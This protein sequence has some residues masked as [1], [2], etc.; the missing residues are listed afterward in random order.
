MDFLYCTPSVFVIDDDYEILINLKENGICYIEI[1]NDTFYEDGSGVLSSESTLI[2]IRIPPKKLDRA[3]KYRVVYRRPIERKAYFSTLEE[4]VC[5]EFDFKPIEKTDNINIYLI[6]DVHYR[7]NIAKTTASYFGDDI[8]LFVVNGD[9]G[10]VETVENYLEVCRFVGE[11]SLGKIPVI[12]VR[13]NHDTRGHL[14]EL[15]T[16]YF[17]KQEKNILFL[18]SWSIFGSCS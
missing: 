11:I 17:L 10:E 18:F 9:I 7:F 12:F 8:D 16:D 1:E 6:A 3:K 15:F 4:P 2:K 5:C 13:G 14:A